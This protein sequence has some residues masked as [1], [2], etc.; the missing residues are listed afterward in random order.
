MNLSIKGRARRNQM[1]VELRQEMS[2][3]HRNRNT[4]RWIARSFVVVFAAITVWQIQLWNLKHNDPVAAIETRQPAD[5]VKTNPVVVSN[6]PGVLDRFLVT[7]S[8]LKGDLDF[9]IVSDDE[10]LGLMDQAGKPSFLGR[11]DGELVVIPRKSL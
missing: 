3:F 2:Q 8:S 11:I 7:D 9:E 4:R 6:Q 10:L 1:L 5:P